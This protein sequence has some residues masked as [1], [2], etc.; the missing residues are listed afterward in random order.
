MCDYA[1]VLI[2]TLNRYD[3]FKRCIESLAKCTHAEK[4]DLFIFLDFPVNES[5]W[6]GYKLIKA[7]IKSIVGFKSMNIVERL[8][9]FGVQKNF[10]EGFKQIFKKY[11]VLIV[12]EDDNVFSVNFLDYINKGLRKFKDDSQIYAICGYNYPIHIPENFSSNYYIANAYSGWGCGMWR[13]KYNRFF[14]DFMDYK[15][16]VSRLDNVRESLTHIISTNAFLSIVRSGQLLG[17]YAITGGLKLKNLNCVFPVITKVKNNGHD[18]SGVNCELLIE[19]N[20]FFEQ[21]L[22]ESIGFTFGA[23]ASN[24]ENKVIKKLLFKYK[25]RNNRF[26]FIIIVC[27]RY[28]IYKITGKS[29]YIFDIN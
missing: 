28:F 4:T 21:K 3:H 24:N 13:N 22:D 25:G 11:D 16:V 12:S 1:P 9:N 26:F 27:I 14:Q 17:D 6:K 5:H 23:P 10:D 7:Y 29:Y 2:C 8:V 15:K 20:I 18:G 19:D